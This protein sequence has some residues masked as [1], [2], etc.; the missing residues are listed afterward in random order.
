MNPAEILS[1]FDVEAPCRDG[2]VL[3]CNVTRPAGEGRHPVIL[4]RT[5]YGKDGSRSD[6]LLD[7]VGLA[8]EGFVVVLQ[9]VRQ[10]G[11]S[12]GDGDFVPFVHEADDGADTVEWAAALPF[13]NGHV[14]TVGPSYLG[15]TQ[16]ALAT[17]NPESL[18]AIAPSQSP[19]SPWR[20]TFYRGGV[21][22]LGAMVPLF[23]SF[24]LD[25]LMRRH[26]K[27]LSALQTSLGG[28]VAHLDGLT[29]GAF[30][31]LPVS[32][33]AGLTGDDVGRAL[34][35]MLA[36]R[37]E[38]TPMVRALVE[39]QSYESVKVPA[40]IT[41]SWYDF[42]C[43]AAIDQF[44]GIRKH[45][46]SERA[47]QRSRLVM[48]PWTHAS[49]SAIHGE[50]HF[51]L[52]GAP[53]MFGQGG[54][55]AETLRFFREQLED[56]PKPTAPVKIF[57]MGANVWR[58]EWEW[59]IART[60]FVPWYFGSEGRANG[61]HGDG[62]LGPEQHPS[63]S[64]RFVYDPASPVPTWGGSNVGAS[65]LPGPRDQRLVEDRTDVLVYT[66]APLAEPLE[67]TGTAV[68]ELWASSSALDTDFVARLV[69]VAPDGTALA[70]A[71]GIL[72]GRYRDNPEQLDVEVPLEPGVPTLFRI[73]LTPTS[74]LFRAGH[75]LRVDVTSSCFPRWERNL[76]V[77]DARNATLADAQ[78]ASQQI[79]HDEAHPS[80]I[81]L[82]VVP[83]RS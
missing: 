79:F 45:G 18:R 65:E 2:V 54:L 74:N 3:R 37:G 4:V 27:N 33:F 39:A 40:L 61:R 42:F 24:G 38:R 51:G 15:F 22:E 82:P 32:E 62:S 63:P 30:E 81:I 46:G 57:V 58:D 52:R 19:S 26:A 28:L 47:R 17:R 64:D 49:Q 72:R 71:E 77:W 16:W 25:M 8:R 76:N 44:V 50:V 1:Q 13:S 68:V 10:R 83:P 5:P 55:R 12:G 21:F 69:D 6:P 14:F 31:N 73:E 29:N 60:R 23:M 34:L 59:P 20:S 9:D 66:S 56:D 41:G 7:A 70:V 48:G 11:R 78:I 67:V 43:Q 36:A 80:R 35:D 53:S 75:R